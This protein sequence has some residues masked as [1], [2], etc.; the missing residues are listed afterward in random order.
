MPKSVALNLELSI[1][2]ER[3]RNCQLQ[4]DPFQNGDQMKYSFVLMVSL[5][6]LAAMVKLKTF[7]E[8]NWRQ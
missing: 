4:T 6:S 5:S 1:L 3:K 7:F 2:R 8:T